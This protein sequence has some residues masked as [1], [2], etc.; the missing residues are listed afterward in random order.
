MPHS[1]K[2]LLGRR[3]CRHRLRKGLD[4]KET[5]RSETWPVFRSKDKKK[6]EIKAKLQKGGEGQEAIE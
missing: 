2:Q 5:G 1:P 4:V 6:Q 3:V